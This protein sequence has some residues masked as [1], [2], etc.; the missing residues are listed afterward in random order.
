MTILDRYLSR[1]LIAMVLRIIMSLVMLFVIIDLLTARQDSIA[2]FDVP[3]GMVVLYYLTFVPTILFEY[4]AVALAVLIAGLMVLGKAAQDQEVTAALAGGISLRRIVL[5]PV[6]V[7]LG[8]AVASFFA[9]DTLGVRAAALA[10][11]IEEQYFSKFS[12]ENRTGISWTNLGG[13]W[14]CHILKFNRV[15]LTGEDVFIH[16]FDTDEI[17]EIRAR[18]IFW[19]KAR[20]CWFL[21]QGRW[22]SFN[23]RQEW[24]QKVLRITQIAA[25]FQESPEEL[26]ALEQP[27]NAKSA[28]TLAH[29]LHHAETLGMPVNSYWVDYYAK[30][31]R[32]AL[33]FIMIWLAIPF[34]IRLRRG[35]IAIG[36]GVSIAIALAYLLLFYVSMGLGYLD[37]IP[38][39]LAAW[40]ANGCFLALGLAL[41]RKTPT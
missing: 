14:T 35:G 33:C 4:Q 13:G 39:L 20:S 23:P 5:G 26:F 38:P 18:R 16:R 30:F 41:F 32:P 28:R 2:R 9:E 6:M 24:E 19:D 27:A 7:A 40:L 31:A 25:P 21:E 17:Q 10:E 37:K 15:A 3:A 11:R 36:F 1:R 34:A 22:C 8:L 12:G 29:D